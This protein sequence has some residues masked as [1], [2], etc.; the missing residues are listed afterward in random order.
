MRSCLHNSPLQGAPIRGCLPKRPVCNL[1]PLRGMYLLAF[2]RN[3][4]F[5]ISND[6]I[7]NLLNVNIITLAVKFI[8]ANEA[9]MLPCRSQKSGK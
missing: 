8:F 3:I 5:E 6:F 2:S 1:A 9:D 7:Y 4:N